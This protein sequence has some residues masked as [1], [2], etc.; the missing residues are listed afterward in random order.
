LWN[1]PVCVRYPSGN[2]NER[3]CSLVTSKSASLR[4]AKAKGCPAWTYAN[5]DEAGY[6]RVRY[7]GD[8]LSSLLKDENTLTLPER[9]GLVGD[10]AALTKGSMSLGDAMALVPRFAHDPH[11]QVVAKTLTIVGGLDEH[12]VPEALIPK[13][14]RYMSDL[15]KARAQQLGWK[16]RP[17]EDDDSRL[18][19]PRVV[20]VVTDHAEDPA[21][22]DQAKKLALAWLDDHKAVDPDMLDVVLTAAARHGDRAVFDRMR[23]QVKKETEEEVR[24]TLLDALGSFHDPAILKTALAIVLTDEFTNRE[25]IEIL[26]ST[27][28]FPETRDLAYDF[29]KQNWDALIAKLPTDWGAFLPFIASHYCDNQHRA[30]AEQFFTGRAT[31]YAGGPRNLAQLLETVSLC[32]A[33]KSANET[34]VAEF[35]KKY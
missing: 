25:S 9:V 13:Y 33:N 11:R 32:V 7:D 2:G 24:K 6:Y 4:L 22:V 30:D 23:A 28:Q 34:S 14:Q 12:L 17:G 15:Y 26:F 5:A 20:E 21:F 31:K 19:R 1:V 8:M 18:L 10:I 27:R 35:L 29:V 3:Q 16:D